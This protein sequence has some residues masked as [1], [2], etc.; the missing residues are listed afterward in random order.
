LRALAAGLALLLAASPAAAFI[1]DAEK[2]TDAAARANAAAG[3]AATLRLGVTLHSGPP[4]AEGAEPIAS[5]SLLSDPGAGSARLELVGVNG[6]REIHVWRPRGA[7]AWRD[8][9]L[10]AEASPLLPPLWLLQ[11]RYGRSLRAA[12]GGLGVSLEDP[13]LGRSDEHDC[14]VIGGRD[15]AAEAA[16]SSRRPALWL[17]VYSFEVVRVDRADGARFRFGP[18]RAFGE[19]RLPAW[20]AVEQAG[21]SPLYLEVLDAAPAQSAAGDFEAP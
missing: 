1:P 19:Q 17:D 2:L 20:V 9:E 14:F 8:G 7:A 3:R 5:G 15:R 13:E 18:L 11:L 21:R 6:V 12:L 4:G 10:L 16:G